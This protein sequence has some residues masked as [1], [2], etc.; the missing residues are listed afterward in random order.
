[1]EILFHMQDSSFLTQK[2]KTV[3]SSPK[4]NM[5]PMKQYKA[6]EFLRLKLT[7]KTISEEKCYQNDWKGTGEK[8]KTMY[9]G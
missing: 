5:G 2:S 1:M 6:I 3:M 8:T 4:E 7:L 9:Q